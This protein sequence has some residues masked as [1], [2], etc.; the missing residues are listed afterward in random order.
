[1]PIQQHDSMGVDSER[2]LV[3]EARNGTCGSEY[4]LIVSSGALAKLL[5]KKTTRPLALTSFNI[6]V[7][8]LA[9]LVQFLLA[10]LKVQVF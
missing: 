5:I 2:M 3:M 8:I 1:M 6:A 4:I 9:S 7:H 10:T